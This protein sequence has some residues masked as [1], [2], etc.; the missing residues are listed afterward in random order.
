MGVKVGLID[1]SGKAVEMKLNMGNLYKQ[2]KDKKM[3]VRTSVKYEASSQ[4]IDWDPGKGDLLDQLFVASG[5]FDSKFG[6]KS[7]TIRDLS[8]AELNGDFRRQD[9]SDQS[10][11]A[12]LL[13]PQ[14]VLET[15]RAGALDDD[16]SDIINIWNGM[17][18]LTTNVDGQRAE[19]PIIDTRAPAESPSG[20]VVQLAEPE[21]MVSITTGQTLHKIPTYAVGLLISNEAQSATTVDLVRIVME[22]QSR[23]EKVRRVREQLAAMINGDADYGMDALTPIAAST[24]DPEAVGGVITKKA[25]IK[26]LYSHQYKSNLSRAITNIDTALALDAALLSEK[27]ADPGV[28]K[29]PF[30]NINVKMPNPEFT[31]LEEVVDASTIVAFDP[32]YAIQRFVNVSAEY[33]AIE[34]YVM[35]KATGFRVDYGESAT[36]LYDEAWSVLEFASN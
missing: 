29:A 17:I 3:D 4:G 26:W 36:R 12:R 28:I 15:L 5:L 24:F 16:G 8:Q 22:A 35:R 19:Q 27:H 9:G 13:F 2:A 11:G 6:G 1:R 14:M 34:E 25:Y 23:G 30:S 33:E 32:R 7:L 10:L 31:L 18:A 20:R 21:T